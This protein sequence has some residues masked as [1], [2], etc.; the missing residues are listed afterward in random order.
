MKNITS[1]FMFMVLALSLN[2]CAEP[3]FTESDVQQQPVRQTYGEQ[4][5]EI[6]AMHIDNG[7]ACN[8]V[9][10]ILVFPDWETF[11]NTSNF[12]EAQ[13]DNMVSAFSQS[14]D[15]GMTD[16][17]FEAYAESMGFKEEQAYLNFEA[18]YQFA[19][20]RK[21]LYDQ[22]TAWLASL[23][24]YE[25]WNMKLDPDNHYIWYEN[26]VLL[27]EQ[28]EVIVKDSLGNNVIYKFYE[29]GHVEIKDNAY[30]YLQ[31]L[32]TGSGPVVGEPITYTPNPSPCGVI[33]E[34]NTDL[35]EP[36]P[37]DN[38]PSYSVPCPPDFG[39]GGGE[40]DG[41][42][43]NSNEIRKSFNTGGGTKIK[44]VDKFE[45]KTLFGNA[46]IKSKTKYYRW[47]DVPIFNGYWSRG[48]TTL[49]AA[50][51]EIQA[52]NCDGNGD[53]A[54]PKSNTRKAFKVKVKRVG[55]ELTPQG[56]RVINYALIGVHKRRQ[57]VTK[58][59]DMYDGDVLP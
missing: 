25:E 28:A 58:E 40:D 31:A 12:L 53:T 21:M 7:I 1:V 11:R 47:H 45:H 43:K 50:I 51:K 37:W 39:G 13:R 19:S 48:K 29:G 34:D 55:I 42:C 14:A 10:N 54:P 41:G 22:E 52:L 27:N 24:Q 8:C 38:F 33:A 23:G 20:L 59:I 9:N 18:Q 26:R 57:D 44:T 17:E 30:A 4:G 6:Y 49:T 32:N 56:P 16:L 15:P 46:R 35:K 2:S 36:D 5:S 3:E